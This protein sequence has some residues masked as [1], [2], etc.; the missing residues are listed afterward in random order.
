VNTF[1][2]NRIPMANNDSTATTSTTAV[3]A[4]ATKSSGT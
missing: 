4:A 3:H 1:N 2:A